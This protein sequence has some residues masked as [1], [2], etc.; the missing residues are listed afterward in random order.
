MRAYPCLCPVLRRFAFLLAISFGCLRFPLVAAE[1]D[2]A[3]L[4]QGDEWVYDAVIVSPDG[5]KFNATGR[6]KI[7]GKVER[8][9]KTYHS[10]KFSIEDGPFPFEKTKWLRKDEKGGYSLDPMDPDAPE[11]IEIIYPLKIGQTWE[12]SAY[13]YR[14][15]TEVIGLEKV[16]IGEKTY[17]K[18]YAFRTT[19]TNG[20]FVEDSWLAPDVGM[21]K[22]EII[23]EGAKFSLTLRE[24][25]RAKL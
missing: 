13:H 2:Y 21:I 6:S 4:D 15:K 23:Q 18:C 25:K 5:Q 19:A 1:A 16:V 22:S 8:N 12:A 24:Y 17:E 14:L 9:G 3:P 10:L 11:Q 20:G 7:E